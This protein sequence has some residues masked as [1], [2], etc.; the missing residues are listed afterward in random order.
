MVMSG[1]EVFVAE[2]YNCRVQVY[3]LDG[4]YKRQWGEEGEGAGQFIRPD[5]IAVSEG[6]VFASSNHR[7]QGFR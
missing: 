6:E 2:C 4:S 5:G 1:D 7:I 3:G